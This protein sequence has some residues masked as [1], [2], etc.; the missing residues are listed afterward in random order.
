[1]QL[2]TQKG[3]IL[4]AMDVETKKSA[5][6]TENIEVIKAL[7]LSDFYYPHEETEICFEL[8]SNVDLK[9]IESFDDL[10]DSFEDST[11]IDCQI[12]TKTK[13]LNFQIKRYPADY[14]KHTNEA[15]LDWFAKT[16]RHYGDMSGTILAILLQPSKPHELSAINP[17]EISKILISRKEKISFDEV[18]FTYNDRN[19]FFTLHRV[20][21]VEKKL[22]IPL[23]W[24]LK[25]M[26]GEV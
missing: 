16:T 7:Q 1:M 23:E 14:L 26:R 8:R 22:G 9:S 18:V 3:P 12:G 17:S 20:Y 5:R 21:P 19:K 2:A 15:F 24:G 25:R 13:S 6:K 11:H 4:E 10:I